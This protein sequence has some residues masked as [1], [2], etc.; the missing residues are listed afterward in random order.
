[1]TDSIRELQEIARLIRIDIVTMIH[2][3]HD[4]PPEDRDDTL[5][6][7]ARILKN[8]G[9]LFIREPTRESHGMPMR[10]LQERLLRAG[11]TESENEIRNS[12][13]RGKFIKSNGGCPSRVHRRA[14]SYESSHHSYRNESTGFALAAFTD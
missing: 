13:V 8:G 1:M 2:V 9:A 12:E 7:L 3:L 10:E 4:I 6:A 5:Q 11:L 14:S